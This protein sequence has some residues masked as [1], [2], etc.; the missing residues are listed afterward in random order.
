MCHTVVV[1]FFPW[2]KQINKQREETLSQACNQNVASSVICTFLFAFWLAI[3]R[4][5][6]RSGVAAA[7]VSADSRVF[8]GL[9]FTSSAGNN[10]W[11]KAPVRFLTVPVTACSSS[12]FCLL[13]LQEM[14]FDP[15]LVVVPVLLFFWP[16]TFLVFCFA[17]G[18]S[19]PF[20]LFQDPGLGS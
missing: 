12:G 20:E 1:P 17:S 11:T 14:N 15:V 5:V 16:S 9:C 8:M 18:T 4:E 13:L 2:N 10:C 7:A 6:G 19:F 3:G